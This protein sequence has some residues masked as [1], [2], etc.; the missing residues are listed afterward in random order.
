[1]LH[2]I[3]CKTIPAP[4]VKSNGVRYS[5]DVLERAYLI[6]WTLDIPSTIA[7]GAAIFVTVVAVV[8]VRMVT[9]E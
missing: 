9:T 8:V 2:T 6:H 5:F 1:M 7:I 4:I 3:L